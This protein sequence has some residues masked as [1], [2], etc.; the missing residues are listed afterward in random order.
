MTVCSSM[1]KRCLAIFALRAEISRGRTME[2]L[3]K[4]WYNTQQRVCLRSQTI[5]HECLCEMTN[6][7]VFQSY[8]AFT[9][10]KDRLTEV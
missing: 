2:P 10:H 5:V 9:L 6:C 7:W 8:N 1:R 3:A 4:C